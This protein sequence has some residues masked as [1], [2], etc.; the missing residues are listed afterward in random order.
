MRVVHGTLETAAILSAEMA[1]EIAKQLGPLGYRDG[2]PV[3]AFAS[4]AAMKSAV[5]VRTASLIAASLAWFAAAGGLGAQPQSD[6]PN[7]DKRHS[8]QLRTRE[9][10]AEKA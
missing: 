7:F 5:T 6:L 3:V 4:F 8:N 1:T 10:A 9:L 2:N